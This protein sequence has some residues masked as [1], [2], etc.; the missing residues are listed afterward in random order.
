MS[1]YEELQKN[2][3]E[4]QAVLGVVGLGFVGLPLAVAK[5]Q[6]GYTVIGFDVDQEKVNAINAGVCYI[7]D[8]PAQELAEQVAAGRLSA[9]SDFS[10]VRRLDAVSICVPTPIDRHKQPDLTYVI[11]AVTSIAENGPERLL[12]ILSSTTFP[13]TTEEIVRPILESHGLVIGKN[14]FLAYSPERIDP[15]NR[16]Y[17]IKKIPRV[18][19]GVTP[20]CTNLASLL[21]GRVLQ[22]KLF[23][24]ERPAI[25]EMAKIVE[26]T[27]RLVNIGLMNELAVL[28]HRMRL[29]IWKV[30][31]AASTKPYGFL[32]FYPGPGIGGH[33]IPVDPYYLVWKAKEYRYTTHLIEKAGEI[34][35]SM[36]SFVV[37]RIAS[38]LNDFGKSL[39]GSR[40]LVIGIAYKKNVADLRESPVLEIL[41]LL[42][43]Y[44]V[45]WSYHDPHIP[46]FQR[47]GRQVDSVALTPEIIAGQ[48][49]IVIAT[50]HDAIDY[51]LVAEHA[52]AIYDTRNVMAG[53]KT[54]GMYCKL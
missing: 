29:D 33:C 28:C 35:E 41:E 52:Y 44:G 17:Q 12:V 49:L 43:Q 26:N 38:I 42:Q 45:V 3:Q 8:V 47:F 54:K 9:T 6:A 40:V 27:F 23:E 51:Q 22:D 11:Q 31:E 15:G 34:N 4:G 53:I 36:P 18:V 25:A 14:G 1:A 7:D 21:Y 37:L 50:D 10:L 5:A 24:V 20:Q 19:G 32:P 46:R 16:Q 48:D 2:I 39:N 13:G 30:I